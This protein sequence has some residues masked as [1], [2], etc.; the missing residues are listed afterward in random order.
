MTTPASTP[1]TGSD[2]GHGKGF[3]LPEFTNLLDLRKAPGYDE[4]VLAALAVAMV[5]PVDPVSDGPDPE[6]GLFVPAGYTYLGQF[7]DH[8]LTLDT[9]STLD[10]NK[11][12]KDP[13]KAS[14]D[15]TNIRSP[16]FDM[17][18]VYGNGPD[19]QPYLYVQADADSTVGPLYKGASM[20]LDGHDLPRGSNGRALIGDKRNDENSIVNQIQQTF[21]KFHNQVVRTL[22]DRGES[23]RG[24]DLFAKARD[25]VRWAYQTIIME[26][27]LPRIIEHTTLNAFVSTRDASK[28]KDDAYVLYTPALRTNLPREFVVAAYRFGHSMVRTGYRLCGLGPGGNGTSTRLPIFTPSNNGDLS[29]LG[30]DP[31]PAAHVIDDWGRFFPLDQPRPGSHLTVNAGNAAE[32]EEYDVRV[33]LQYAYKIDPSLTDPLA[34]LPGKVASPGDVPAGVGPGGP[35]SLALLNLLRGNRYLIQGG[36]A[37]E[38]IVNHKL[39]LK[40]LVTREK[41]KDAKGNDQYRFVPIPEQLRKD[42]PLWFYILA[43]AQRPLV[44][45][46]LDRVAKQG[47]GAMLTADDLLGR[48][49]DPDPTH[50]EVP[51]QRGLGGQLGPVGGLIV[52]EV[53]YGLLDN[54]DRSVVYQGSGYTPIWGA[55]SH[56]FA[57]LLQFTGLPIT[58][59]QP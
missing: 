7:I 3:A 45:L 29:L 57:R 16:R 52:A 43:E 53:F 18:C 42:T 27:Y 10:V 41:S 21:I 24:T 54:D 48:T 47:A 32:G 55:G 12:L 19:D 44:D 11:D 31:L 25:Q 14:N 50:P 15:P 36:Q 20:V 59:D 8:D 2:G 5:S 34:H 49:P 1:L 58:N 37:F 22:V 26:D 35:P 39:D 13:T 23:D 28:H 4:H 46:W 33:R 51:R 9:T 6:E 17:D 30:F 38:T 40:Y 56:T